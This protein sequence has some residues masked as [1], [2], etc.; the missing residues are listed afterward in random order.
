V[1]TLARVLARHPNVRSLE[2]YNEEN[3]RQW[4]DGSAG[5]YDSVLAT[6]AASV[7]AFAPRLGVLAGGTVWPDA[8]WTAHVCRAARVDAVSFHAYP[9][10]WTPDSVTI[11]N[12]LSTFGYDRFVTVERATCAGAPVWINETGFATVPGKTERDQ[13][14]WWARAIATFL[15]EPEVQHIG[16]YRIKDLRETAPAIGGEPNYHLGLTYA[17]RRKKLAFHTVKLLAGLLASDSLTITDR[18]LRVDGDTGREG[19]YIH[20]FRR[21]DGTQIL[22]AWTRSGARDL[23]VT[24][25]YPVHSVTRYSIDGNGRVEGARENRVRLHLAPGEVEILELR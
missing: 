2:I 15:A 11:E 6:A 5:A 22:L 19:V 8:D 7:R 12:Y 17:N 3:T 20:G 23:V 13:A 14:L 21:R 16:I 24:L 18:L 4:W 1:D 25:P 9:E 10:T